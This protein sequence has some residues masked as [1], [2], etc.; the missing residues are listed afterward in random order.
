MLPFGKF[1]CRWQLRLS[2]GQEQSIEKHYSQV[3]IHMIAD[4]P[5]VRLAWCIV[6][7]RARTGRERLPP[8]DLLITPLCTAPP[9]GEMGEGGVKGDAQW[10]HGRQV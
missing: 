10:R 9:A 4:V 6:G 1:G 8:L 7:M 5:S 2:G 3:P